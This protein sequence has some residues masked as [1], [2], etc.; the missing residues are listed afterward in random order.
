MK[1]QIS[2]SCNNQHIITLPPSK[3]L[4]HRYIIAAC[5]AKGKSVIQNIDYSKD[6]L[7][8]INAMRNLN[9]NIETHDNYV[10]IEG[11][12]DLQLLNKVVQCEESGSTLRFLIPLFSIFNQEVIF[13]GKGRLLQRPQDVYQDI[14]DKQL[15]SFYH[16]DENIII[17]GSFKSGDYSIRG[18]ISSQFITGLL[19]PLPLLQGDS[20]I[21]V[22]GEFE[23]KSYVNLTIDVLSKFGINIKMD[24]NK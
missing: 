3:S 16:D 17:K 4:A 8:T 9:I 15:I 11:K 7:A 21:E 2:P 22:I 6:I 1:V 23:S 10:V 24:E 14:A 19:Y 18:D 13:I 20:T 12:N 5:L